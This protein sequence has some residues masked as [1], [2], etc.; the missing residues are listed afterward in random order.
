MSSSGSS[1]G[2]SSRDSDEGEWSDRMIALWSWQRALSAYPLSAAACGGALGGLA[3]VWRSQHFL[4]DLLLAS[5]ADGTFAIDGTAAIDWGDR[6]FE[7]IVSYVLLL[8]VAAALAF[9]AFALRD[10]NSRK[11]RT[12]PVWP[13]L[14]SALSLGALA[15]AHIDRA[16]TKAQFDPSHVTASRVLEPFYALDTLYQ[17]ATLAG[18]FALT[19]VWLSWWLLRSPT[20]QQW[21]G[22]G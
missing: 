16:L 1:G 17:R 6:L 18:G 20:R 10:P 5:S 12:L 2:K 9:F 13:L 15:S 14:V 7:H 8:I 21:S 19:L 22:S 3:S 11:P 4:D